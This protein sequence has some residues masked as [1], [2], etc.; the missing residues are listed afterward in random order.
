MLGG[1]NRYRTDALLLQLRTQSRNGRTRHHRYHSI[2][3]LGDPDEQERAPHNLHST[4]QAASVTFD[5]KE[6]TFNLIDTPGHVEVTRDAIVRLRI[7]GC[8]FSM[9]IVLSY[10]S[11]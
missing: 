5:W 1:A 4:I 8:I 6:H 2:K 3:L 7:N 11:L 9:Q 10:V